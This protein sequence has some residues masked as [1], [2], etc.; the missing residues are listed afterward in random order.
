MYIASSN[1]LE[2]Y[3]AILVKLVKS[4]DEIT[5]LLLEG[6]RVLVL[7]LYTVVLMLPSKAK[8]RIKVENRC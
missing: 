3:V 2:R 7:A 8:K 4:S 1:I 5:V 6:T